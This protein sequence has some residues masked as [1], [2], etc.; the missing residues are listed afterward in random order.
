MAPSPDV[1]D[2]DSG[3]WLFVGRKP[4]RGR[5][6]A[7]GISLKAYE[8]TYYCR[9]VKQAAVRAGLELPYYKSTH[10]MRNYCASQLRAR[11]WSDED[12]GRWI[13]DASGTIAMYYGKQDED[14]IRRMAADMT[15]DR[16]RQDTGLR[17]VS[18]ASK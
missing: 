3:A 11:G 7:Q 18:E 14:V 1:N 2:P 8:P 4:A 6:H 5:H 10:S 9:L 12:I 16:T 17:V 13:G 15:A